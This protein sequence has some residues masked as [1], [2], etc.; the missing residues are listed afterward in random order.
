MRQSNNEKT[1]YHG[2]HLL[3]SVYLIFQ[4]INFL[5]PDQVVSLSAEVQGFHSG[6]LQPLY[7]ADSADASLIAPPDAIRSVIALPRIG[8]KIT[9]TDIP[10]TSAIEDG[11]V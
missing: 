9:F 3:H 5:N 11:S 2:T 10:L 6:N 7:L 8:I 1:T 4:L